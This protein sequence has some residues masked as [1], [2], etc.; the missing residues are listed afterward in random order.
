MNTSVLEGL[1]LSKGEIKVYLALLGIGS[2]K[3]GKVIESSGMASSAVHAALG[4]LG[5]K[6]LISHVKKGKVK[7][8]HSVSPRQLINFIDDKKQ[9]VLGILPELENKQKS[10]EFVQEAEVFTGLKGINSL[11]TQLITDSK[12]GEEYLF[13]SSNVPGRDDEIQDFFLRF[14][15]KRKVKGLVTKGIASPELKHLFLNRPYLSMKYTKL[16]IPSNMT[17]FRNTI[18]FLSW[19]DEPQGFIIKSRQLTDNFRTLFYE[20]WNN[21]S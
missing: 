20:V 19:G 2:T 17:I 10:A 13:F 9:E 21:T 14:D 16:P 6:G 7:W 3:A 12:K 8:Y 11:L 18:V 5:D 4:T 1:G 15:Q